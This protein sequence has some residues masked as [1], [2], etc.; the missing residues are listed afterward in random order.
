MNVEELIKSPDLLALSGSFQYGTNNEK[1]DR[2]FIGVVLPTAEVL[3]GLENFEQYSVIADGKDT[4]IYSL[5]EF[6]KLLMQGQTR[7]I[8]ILFSNEYIATEL[9]EMLLTNRQLFLSKKYYRTIKGFSFSEFLKG[10]G[11]GRSIE[12]RDAEEKDLLEA[13]CGKFKLKSYQRDELLKIVYEALDFNPIKQVP[14]TRKLGEKRKDAV[15]EFGYSP[16][17]MSHA[18]RLLHQGCELLAEGKL[19]FPRPEA[20]TLREIKAGQWKLEEIEDAYN[21][22]VGKLDNLYNIS[23]LP[24][25]PNFNDVNALYIQ[26]VQERIWHD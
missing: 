13:I 18:L 16:K 24:K 21:T 17:N 6:F 20:Q 7:P 23:T 25:V 19:T 1:S 10:K 14:M 22:M 26:L 11:L 12:Y 8:E 15:A 4:T 3:L 2:D 9:G 5:K